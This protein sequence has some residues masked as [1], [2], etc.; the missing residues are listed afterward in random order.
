MRTLFVDFGNVIAFFDHHRAVAR[1]ARYTHLTPTALYDT[2]YGDVLEEPYERGA[3]STEQ[4][5]AAAIRAAEMT[6]TPAEFRT[7]FEDIFTRNDEVCDLIPMLADTTRLVLASNTNAMHFAKYTEQFADVLSHFAHLG[8]SHLAGV[9]K[10]NAG[11]FAYCQ[12]FASAPAEDCVFLDDIPANVVAG[13]RHG[14]NG[15]LYRPG[16]DVAGQLRAAGLQLAGESR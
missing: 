8:A 3:L 7:A 11:F 16:W 2:L 1:L 12:Q 14:W 9:R 6:C 4:Y 13:E 15:V 10:P 5:T